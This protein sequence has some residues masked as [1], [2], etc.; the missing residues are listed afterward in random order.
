MYCSVWFFLGVRGNMKVTSI[1]V[2]TFFFM[3]ASVF[4]CLL[5]SSRSPFLFFATHLHKIRFLFLY[6]KIT[7]LL[8]NFYP[9]TPFRLP[10]CFFLFASLFIYICLFVFP[11][12]FSLFFSP[13]SPFPFN[14]LDSFSTTP[15]SCLPRYPV[16]FPL[17]PFIHISSLPLF[18]CPAFPS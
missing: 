8:S 5:S 9:P 2:S 15:L 12:F 4:L 17:P 10:L 16:Y 6:F 3:Q 13:L 1:R 18:C 11:L 7:F 14:L